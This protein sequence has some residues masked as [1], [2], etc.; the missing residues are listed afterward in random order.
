M[1][2]WDL[3]GILGVWIAVSGLLERTRGPVGHMWEVHG[4][5][6]TSWRMAFLE[7]RAGLVPMVL[8]Q[9]TASPQK[10]LGHCT[11]NSQKPYSGTFLS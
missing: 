6:V 10:C 4:L 8:R 2:S 5:K 9:D 1:V 7:D 11:P 3:G